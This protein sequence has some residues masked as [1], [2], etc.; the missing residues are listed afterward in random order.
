LV[1][2]SATAGTLSSTVAP[3]AWYPDSASWGANLGGT[4]I[5]GTA[6]DLTGIANLYVAYQKSLTS[7]NGSLAG[8]F[9][10]LTTLSGGNAV[11][12]YLSNV[13]GI[14]YFNIAS[15][16]AVPEADTFGMMFVWCWLDGFHCASPS[17]KKLN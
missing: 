12:A 11:T 16:A 8:G 4:G 6:I 13:G 15:V 14:E 9:A 10:G 7:S 2:L 3:D 5:T 1:A 17:S